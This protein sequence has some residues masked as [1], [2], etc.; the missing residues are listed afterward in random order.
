MRKHLQF[1]IKNFNYKLF[2]VNE[3]VMKQKSDEVKA[4]VICLGLT[5]VV[6]QEI[7][8]REDLR[9][10][11]MQQVLIHELTHAFIDAY[12]FFS[13]SFTTEELCEFNEIYLTDISSLAEEIM[14]ELFSNGQEE[15]S[16]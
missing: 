5:K 2:L 11:R 3:E 7:Y 8:I 9:P 16:N 13:R 10:V 14:R 4:E 1:V 12:G 15:E 6:E